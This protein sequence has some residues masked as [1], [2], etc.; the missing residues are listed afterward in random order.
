LRAVKYRDALQ[1]A[2]AL[3]VEGEVLQVGARQIIM[4][5]WVTA[6]QYI[7]LSPCLVCPQGRGAIIKGAR[8]MVKTCAEILAVIGKNIEDIQDPKVSASDRQIKIERAD[9]TQKLA[10][11]F[12]NICNF[13]QKGDLMAGRHDRT[14]ALIGN[15]KNE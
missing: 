15:I 14:D 9:N 2:P 5:L 10:K 6:K 3:I 11:Q 12:V 7:T 13:V 4:V 1:A 8:K